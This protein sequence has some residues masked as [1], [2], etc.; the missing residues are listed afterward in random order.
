MLEGK[1]IRTQ[2]MREVQEEQEVRESNVG[3]YNC[4]TTPEILTDLKMRGK[5]S[6]QTMWVVLDGSVLDSHTGGTLV[7]LLLHKKEE[8]YY[9]GLEGVGRDNLYKHCTSNNRG[10]LDTHQAYSYLM[11]VIAALSGLAILRIELQ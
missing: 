7:W 11:E 5:N 1:I 10:I 3:D 9:W 6:E 8:E 2:A 4:W